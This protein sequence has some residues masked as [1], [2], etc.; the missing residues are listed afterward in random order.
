[1]ERLPST[2]TATHTSTTP[3][4]ERKKEKGEK[5]KG[6]FAGLVSRKKGGKGGKRENQR[7]GGN[8]IRLHLSLT[9]ERRKKKG[10]GGK[11]REEKERGGEQ[12]A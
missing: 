2:F 3:F 10:E 5:K 7:T 11:R 1:M 4:R 9:A 8:G 12:D 6:S